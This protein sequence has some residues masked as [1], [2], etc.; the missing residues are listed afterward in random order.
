MANPSNDRRGPQ[1]GFAAHPA[2]AHASSGAPSPEPALRVTPAD[3]VT[4]ARLVKTQG[5]KGE[6][7]AEPLTDIAGRFEQVSRVFLAHPAGRRLETT[8]T[9]HWRHGERIVL[10]FADIPDMNAAEA[11]VGAEVQIPA[12]ER[13]AAPTDAYFVDD[14]VGCELWDG[15]RALGRV[16]AV[17]PVPGAAPL[18]HVAAA[19]GAELL[20]PFVEAYLIQ[21]SL[22]ERRITMRLPEG[23]VDVNAL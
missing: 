20:I 9:R 7:A 12:A 23:L 8:L 11:W 10:A 19:G 4:L 1:R 13:A 15:E 18:L 2:Y 17:E 22:P 14:L 3:W 5:H 16:S 6:L 21:V